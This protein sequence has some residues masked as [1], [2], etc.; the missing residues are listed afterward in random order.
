M[1][2]IEEPACRPMSPPGGHLGRTGC[3]G[4]DVDVPLG[5]LLEHRATFSDG[6]AAGKCEAGGES[7]RVR[8]KPQPTARAGASSLVLTH[9]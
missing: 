9:S 6:P 2:G 4:T 3:D 7:V 5:S 1:L 8:A